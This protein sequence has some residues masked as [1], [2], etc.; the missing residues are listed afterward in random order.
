MAPDK[1]ESLW[2]IPVR[3]DEVPEEGREFVLSADAGV[4]ARI[5]RAAG[6][7]DLARLDATL[8]VTRDGTRVTGRI[9]ATITQTCVVTLEPLVNEIDEPVEVIFAPAAEQSAQLEAA[10]ADAPDP[11]EPLVNG[12]IDLGAL[13]A[14]FLL[15]GLDP[16]PRKPDAAFAAPQDEAGRDSPFAALAALRKSDADK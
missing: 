4:R 12:T 6:L 8:A 3:V 7:V 15:L 14:E 9:S 11:P 2:S 16:Y 1:G 13:A 5:A 10:A